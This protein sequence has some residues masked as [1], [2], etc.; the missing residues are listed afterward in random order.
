VEQ[1][2]P[3]GEEL[4]TE[5]WDWKVDAVAVGNGTGGTLLTCDDVQ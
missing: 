3:T 4:V 1:V 5:N 2:L